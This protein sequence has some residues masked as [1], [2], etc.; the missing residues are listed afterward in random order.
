MRTAVAFLSLLVA[1]LVF[2]TRASVAQGYSYPWCAVFDWST[3]NCGFVSYQQCLSYIYGVGGYCSENP[4]Y[5]GGNAA[6]R[7]YRR[8]GH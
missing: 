7:K 8:S 1:I 6:H 4:N 3:R 2:D 5:R